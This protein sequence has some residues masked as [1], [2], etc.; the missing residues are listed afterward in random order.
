MNCYLVTYTF[1]NYRGTGTGRT[2]VTDT[3]TSP[4]RVMSWE[5]QIKDLNRFDSVAVQNIVKLDSDQGI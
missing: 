4:A 5:R 2:F 3:G 1:T